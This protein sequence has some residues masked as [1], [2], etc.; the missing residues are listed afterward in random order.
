MRILTVL[1]GM[2]GLLPAGA[3]L[4]TGAALM[5]AP[6]HPEC[7]RYV[8]HMSISPTDADQRRANARSMIAGRVAWDFQVGSE[9]VATQ[10]WFDPSAAM[11]AAMGEARFFTNSS[12][13]PFEV[14]TADVLTMMIDE[15]EFCGARALE[16]LAAS[17][18]YLAALIVAAAGGARKV[19][20]M[21][22]KDARVM[23][24]DYPLNMTEAQAWKIAAHRG[25][26]LSKQ[27]KL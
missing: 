19:M 22:W 1:L 23:T 3:A 8:G 6:M 13:A 4:A 24:V 18:N 2:I 7:W 11:A 9:S 14:S 5:G 10:H 27:G 15:P 17:E 26:A 21:R 25:R 12:S 16:E 20:T